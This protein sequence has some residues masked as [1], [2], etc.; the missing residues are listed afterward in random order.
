MDE[1]S[2]A[3]P[4]K[5]WPIAQFIAIAMLG[6]ALVPSNPYGYYILL[7]VVV[8]GVCAF[9]ASTANDSNR[10]GWTWALGVTAVIY[11]PVFPLHLTREI[12]SVV[13]IATIL[14]LGV[15]VWTLRN[16][17]SGEV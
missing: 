1:Q 4:D 12:W 7:R 9:L 11:N 15:T 17:T 13:N 3:T 14:M 10:V 8:C 16:S 5:P 6:W 2:H